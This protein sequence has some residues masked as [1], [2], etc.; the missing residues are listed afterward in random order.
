MPA[1]E[2]VGAHAEQR[3]GLVE[4]RPVVDDLE[5]DDLAGRRGRGA[6]MRASVVAAAIQ[7]RAAASGSTR[8]IDADEHGARGRHEID[9]AGGG[10]CRERG[11]QG[12]HGLERPDLGEQRPVAHRQH[13][14]RGGGI[15]G[16]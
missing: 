11:V 15:A 5:L 9:H 14:D 10:G 2:L 3:R 6:G 8:R 12:Q 4:V 13:A 16:L 1:H 7:A